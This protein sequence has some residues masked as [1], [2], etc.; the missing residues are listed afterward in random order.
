LLGAVPKLG[1]SLEHAG[2]TRLT[3]IQGQVPSLR[4]KL[5]GC[6]FAGRCPHVTD[7]CRQVTPAVERKALR[8]FAACHHAG[9]IAERVA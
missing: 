1:S 9:R 3:E 6:A 8:H 5:V 2:R 7:V 4:Q